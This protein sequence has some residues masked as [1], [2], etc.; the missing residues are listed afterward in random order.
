VN[1]RSVAAQMCPASSFLEVRVIGPLRV[2]VDGFWLKEADQ[3]W[4][5]RRAVE[6]LRALALAGGRLSRAEA[7]AALWPAAG[8]REAQVSL[9]VTLH[10][11]R[12]A[13]EPG[14]EGPGRF[15]DYDGAQLGMRANIGLAID[16][17]EAERALQRAA[18]ARTANLNGEALALYARTIE[19]F[20]KLQ[21]EDEVEPWLRPHVRRWR[22]LACV[23][24]RGGAETSITAGNVA[25][26]KWY[27][28]RA[29]QLE[30]LDEETVGVALDVALATHDLDGA[31]S[32]FLEL[33]GRLAGELRTAPSRQL[34]AKYEAVVRLRAQRR[35]AELTA[36]ELEI[37]TFVGR[38]VGSKQIAAKLGRSSRSIDAHVGR[39]LRKMGVASR[40]A[41]VAAA[42]G[43]IEV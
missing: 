32:R 35:K 40:A 6:L 22:G 36:R 9:R 37:L 7:I 33:K 30:P 21:S 27:V 16:A 3:R 29:L 42:G 20:G 28:E 2:R 5:R 14:S 12:R 41:A 11:L 17:H 39:I 38:G 19:I 8:P 43:L 1:S 10:A 25:A 34:A 26:A 24:L 15:V 23:A 31:R 18:L 4:R 13:L